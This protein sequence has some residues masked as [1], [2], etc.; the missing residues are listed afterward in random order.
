MPDATLRVSG[1]AVP[2][3]ALF[4]LALSGCAGRGAP[5]RLP[6]SGLPPKVRPGAEEAS[7]A[8]IVATA[9][10]LL[11]TPYRFGGRSPEAFDCSGLVYYVFSRHGIELPSGVREQWKVGERVVR[12]EITAGDLVF[13]VTAGRSVSHV[14]IAVDSRTFIHAPNS[15]SV[16]RADRMDRGYWGA[17]LAGARRVLTDHR[18]P[19]ALL[20]DAPD[21]Q[22]R[23]TVGSPRR[24][25]P[26][27]ECARVV[28]RRPDWTVMHETPPSRQLPL[29][30]AGRGL[31]ASWP[32]RE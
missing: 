1:R 26:E 25:S 6:G 23:S 31:S 17:R 29:A 4:V 10:S 11:G 18:L 20:L 5:P 9:M 13:F 21:A 7:G 19:Q 27:A 3:A 22:R 8:P 30:L 14:G 24:V 12:D 28:T 15:N 2:A 32:R 16:V